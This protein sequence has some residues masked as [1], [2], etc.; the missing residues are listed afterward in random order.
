MIERKFTNQKIKELQV[1]SYILSQLMRIGCSKIEIKRTPLGERIVVYTSRPGLIVGRKGE[2]ISRLTNAL[3]SRFKMENPQIEVGE[4]ENPDLDPY[5]VADKITYTLEKFGPKRFKFIGYDSLSKIMKAGAMGAEIVIGGAG[6]PGARAKSWRFSAGYLKK[7]GD[8]SDNQILKAQTVAKLKRATV[9]IK[10][11][12]MPPDLKL[13][14]RIEFKEADM[15]VEVVE[16][17]PKEEKKEKKTKK[18]N[19]TTKERK[20]VRKP[21][22]KEEK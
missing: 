11:S 2:N 6:V 10:V 7:S 14:D 8:V 22:K 21:R 16:E 4:I 19:K 12:I 17:I 9:G 20:P 5:S 18:E 15:K 3:K 13:P 1:R